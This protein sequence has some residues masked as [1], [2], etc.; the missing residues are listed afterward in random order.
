MRIYLERT[1]LRHF[2]RS[3][4]A[5]RNRR[6][7]LDE[8]SLLYGRNGR[9]LNEG[10]VQPATV[11]MAQM[12]FV[13]LRPGF[14]PEAGSFFLCNARKRRTYQCVIALELTVTRYALNEP[15]TG[16]GDI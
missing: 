16:G 6:S 15:H 12:R 4:T 8:D 11:F 5:E 7:Q 14:V 10:R 1:T 3:R 2:Q 9:R 13:L